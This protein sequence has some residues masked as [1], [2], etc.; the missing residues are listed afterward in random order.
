M[1]RTGEKAYGPACLRR[2]L[3]APAFG[4]AGRAG[5]FQKNAGDTARAQGCLCRP[6]DVPDI[7]DV[8]KEERRGIEEC[9]E[10]MGMRLPRP[11]AQSPDSPPARSSDREGKEAERRAACDL[12]QPPEAEAGQT[13][14]EAGFRTRGGA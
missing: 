1:L 4:E 10:S 3:Q 9:R 6:E 14:R 11:E 2:Q 7:M 13:V 5:Q 12:V 8:D